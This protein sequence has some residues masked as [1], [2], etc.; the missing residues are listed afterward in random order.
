MSQ[1]HSHPVQTVPV[2]TGSQRYDILV[3]SGL[4][5]APAT[6]QTCARAG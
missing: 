4:L 1:T 6:W 5:D 3:G 2:D